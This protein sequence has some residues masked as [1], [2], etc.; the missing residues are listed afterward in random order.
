VNKSKLMG[1]RPLASADTTVT[2]ATSEPNVRHI[3]LSAGKVALVDAADYEW[4]S[5]WHWSYSKGYARCFKD[6][7]QAQSPAVRRPP[8]AAAPTYAPRGA[9]VGPGPLR[10]VERPE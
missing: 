10:H 1:R 4:L 8:F 2:V 7:Q 3:H 9:D 5:Q 6:E